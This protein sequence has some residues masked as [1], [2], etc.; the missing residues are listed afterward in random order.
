MTIFGSFPYKQVKDKGI[1]Y[2]LR[3]SDNLQSNIIVK[4]ST[5]LNGYDT[6]KPF[7]IGTA[8]SWVSQD[9]ENSWLLVYFP[10]F[11]VKVTSYSMKSY[12][13][14]F[15][16]SWSLEARNGKHSNWVNVSFVKDRTALTSDCFEYVSCSSPN[17][18]KMYR[19]RMYG[20]RTNFNSYHFEILLLEFFGLIGTNSICSTLKKKYLTLSIS[21]I[22]FVYVS[23]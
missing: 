23:Y 8:F 20:K 19:I 6:L 13:Y 18:Y 17:F 11:K 1:F 22:T 5:L 4:N 15:P 21:Y 10:N 16:T 3:D 14:A 12:C 9:I 2:Y 7:G